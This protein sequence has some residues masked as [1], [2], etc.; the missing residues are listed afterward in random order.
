MHLLA[1]IYIYI[2]IYIY[3]IISYIKYVRLSEQCDRW[4]YLTIYKLFCIRNKLYMYTIIYSINNMLPL[5]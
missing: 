2:Y 5:Y 1:Y 4:I 3:T